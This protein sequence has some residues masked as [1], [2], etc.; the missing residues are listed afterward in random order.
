MAVLL[1]AAAPHAHALTC[2]EVNVYMGGCESYLTNKGLLGDCCSGV[3]Q[4]DAAVTTTVDRQT[5]CTCLKA[6]AATLPGFDWT[7]A[8]LLP[9]TCGVS[10]PYII[11]AELACSTIQ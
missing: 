8:A 3:K 11:S 7:K 1:A 10:I 9:L 5:A 6:D 2:T 4:L